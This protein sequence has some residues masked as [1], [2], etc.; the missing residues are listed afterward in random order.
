MEGQSGFRLPL[1]L[2]IMRSESVARM[3]MLLHGVTLIPL[4]FSG[5]PIWIQVLTAILLLLNVIRVLRSDF[6]RECRLI[7]QT[8][9]RWLLDTGSF[10]YEEY[11]LQPGCFVHPLLTILVFRRHG[12]TRTIVLTQDNV[13]P[14]CFR[15]LRVWLLLPEQK[16]IA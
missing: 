7:L 13:E 1:H 11:V 12:K 3:V 8:G 2:N 6:N 14:E 9:D 10:V 16:P 5:A 4:I 15:R